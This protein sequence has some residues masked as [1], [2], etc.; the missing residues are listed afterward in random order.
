MQFL[1]RPSE[2]IQI[3]VESVAQSA[4][5]YPP[6]TQVHACAAVIKV[7]PAAQNAALCLLQ[8]L[9]VA[10]IADY[11]RTSFSSPQERILQKVM[12][13]HQIESVWRKLLKKPKNDQNIRFSEANFHFENFS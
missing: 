1:K 10:A 4:D 7:V 13:N 3:I 12:K 2:A 8:N 9:V 11:N 6:D 5:R